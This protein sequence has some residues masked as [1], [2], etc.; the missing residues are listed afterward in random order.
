MVIF[1]MKSSINVQL[2]GYKNC[3]NSCT[4]LH[5]GC[6]STLAAFSTAAFDFLM[7]T[8]TFAAIS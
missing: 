4:V 7:P 6:G 1:L 8:P 2:I 5:A 3:L